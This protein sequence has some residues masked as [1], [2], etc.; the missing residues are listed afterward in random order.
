[1]LNQPMTL[2]DIY[3]AARRKT[4]EYGNRPVMVKALGFNPEAV[5]NALKED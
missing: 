5:K 1:M 4:P 2:N 3:Y